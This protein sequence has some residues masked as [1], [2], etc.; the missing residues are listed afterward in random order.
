VQTFESEELEYSMAEAAKELGVSKESVRRWIQDGK[1]QAV[2]KRKGH[3]PAWYI[4]AFKV[5]RKK[6][7]LLKT[8]IVRVAGEERTDLVRIEDIEVA[9][10]EAVVGAVGDVV[11]KEIVE[12]VELQ[13][14]VYEELQAE[15]RSLREEI[16]ALREQ[17][18][19][20]WWQFW[21]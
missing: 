14:E 15:I 12:L 18:K 2:M 8:K 13:R 3:L 1:I 9:V 4:P 10:K 7:E 11:K 5:R 16:S 21:K 6:E 17:K 19:K 20:K